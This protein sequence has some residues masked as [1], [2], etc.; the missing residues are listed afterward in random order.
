MAKQKDINVKTTVFTA[1]EEIKRIEA[2]VREIPLRYRLLIALGFITGRIRVSGRMIFRG[3][4]FFYL[5]GVL[6]READRNVPEDWNKIVEV[7]GG[8]EVK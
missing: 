6:L 8:G 5:N 7:I 4:N 2:D 3:R 1:G